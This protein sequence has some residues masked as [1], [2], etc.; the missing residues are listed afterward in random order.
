[1]SLTRSRS[2]LNLCDFVKN[3][4]YS[5]MFRSFLGYYA[6]R[7]RERGGELIMVRPPKGAVRVVDLSG[8]EGLV[9]FFDARGE[10]LDYLGSALGA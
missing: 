8:F 9:R 5:K 6:Q 2:Y 3:K 10:A 7:A 1:M 4:M